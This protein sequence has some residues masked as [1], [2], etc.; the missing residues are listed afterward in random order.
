MLE[1]TVYNLQSFIRERHVFRGVQIHKKYEIRCVSLQ[2]TCSIIRHAT[3]YE[4]VHWS[5]E[6]D[7]SILT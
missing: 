7:L 6:V 3:G 4:T 5:T 2:R 1:V